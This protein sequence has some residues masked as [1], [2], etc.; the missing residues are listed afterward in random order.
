MS[1]HRISLE[2]FLNCD[3]VI[4]VNLSCDGFNY[5]KSSAITAQFATTLTRHTH[6][7]SHSARQVGDMFGMPKCQSVVPAHMCWQQSSV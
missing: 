2:V 1:R 5:S 6:T 7:H 4:K 3:I